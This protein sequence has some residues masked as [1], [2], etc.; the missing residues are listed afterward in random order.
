MNL[1]YPVFIQDFY[2][3]AYKHQSSEHGNLVAEQLGTSKHSPELDSG[4]GDRGTYHADD[5]GR[6]PY[7]HANHG[8]GKA[9]GHGVYAGGHGQHDELH[10][11]GR[12]AGGMRFLLLS[13]KRFTQHVETDKR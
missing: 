8:K 9:H 10:T 3:Y 7:R 5:H 4:S 11:T 2:A 6:S 12:I 13:E 1:Q